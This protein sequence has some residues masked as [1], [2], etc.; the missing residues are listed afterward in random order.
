GAWVVVSLLA[1]SGPGRLSLCGD[2]RREQPDDSLGRAVLFSFVW[3][4]VSFVRSDSTSPIAC[5]CGN[6]LAGSGHGRLL[7]LRCAWPPVS[8]GRRRTCSTPPI[9][10]DHGSDRSM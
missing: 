9:S 10:S 8:A 2:W 4:P 5:G 7:R 6:A 1:Y 3:L